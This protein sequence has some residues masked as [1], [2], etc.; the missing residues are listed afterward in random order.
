VPVFLLGAL[1]LVFWYETALVPDV[2]EPFDVQ[3]FSSLAV[4]DD[5]NAFVDYRLAR[6]RLVPISAT[7]ADQK[8]QQ[9]ASEGV[10]ATISSGWPQSNT[11]ARHWL[12]VNE[13]ALELWKLGTARPDA[14]ASPPDQPLAEDIDLLKASREFVRL[15]LMQAARVTAEKRPADAWTWY[16]A[17]LR[18]SRHIELHTGIIGRLIGGALYSMGMEPVLKWS[19]RSELTAADLRQALTD[20]QAIDAMTPPL[21]GTLKANYVESQRLVVAMTGGWTG[22]FFRVAGYRIRLR[23]DLKMVYANWLSQCDRPRFLRKPHAA[24]QWLL[25]DSDPAAPA[26]P[27]VLPPAE[28]AQAC[29]LTDGSLPSILIGLQMPQMEALFDAVDREEARRSALVLGLALQLFHREHGHFPAKLDE[30]V[31]AKYLPAIPADP[32]G[33]GEPF[34]YRREADPKAG[35]LLWSVWLDGI[36]QEGKIEADPQHA[37]SPGDKIFRIATPR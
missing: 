33:R 37:E 7:E 22:L 11:Q 10:S 8:S 16:R 24:T 29:G 15:G 21:S 36:D 5:Q 2:G 30:L 3:R 32:Y 31:Q 19:S 25:F 1:A 26:N 14:L 12:D 34:H 28:I 27:Q 20:A 23:R 6:H 13:S 18:S 4:P 35:V 9:A 17:V